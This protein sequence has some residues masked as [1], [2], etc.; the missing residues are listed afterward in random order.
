MAG[1]TL[2][3]PKPRDLGDGF[4]VRRALPVLEARHVGPFIF[5]DE[6][7]PVTFAP[8]QGLDVRP[9]PHIGLATVTYLFDGAI[10]HRDS[11]GTVLVI[12]PGDVNWMTAGRGIVHS[13]RS[14]QP[15]NGGA[16]H[17][18]QFWV[19]LP[20]A[21]EE[22]APAFI[23]TPARDLPMREAEGLRVR[24]ICGALGALVSPVATFAPMI[25]LD[26]GFDSAGEHRFATAAYDEQAVYV[27]S[28]AARVDGVAVAAGELLLLG[29]NAAP[30][31]IVREP[32]RAILFGGQAPDGPRKLVWNFVSSRPERIEQAKADWAGQT[33]GR[34]PGETEF[35]PFP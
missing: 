7:G 11:L 28:G 25:Y 1:M 30:T 22:A 27:V 14:P 34:V 32:T 35:I 17:G 18:I 6:M 2:I 24:V 4:V 16:L 23:H 13:E 10:E 29:A 21:D 15:R 33:M 12:R 9:H 20:A 8:G 5:L 19:A 3:K 26:L 31:M